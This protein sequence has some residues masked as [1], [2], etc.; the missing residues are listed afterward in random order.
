MKYKQKGILAE[1]NWKPI[2]SFLRRPPMILIIVLELLA[3][4]FLGYR[5]VSASEPLEFA[6][7]EL[8]NMSMS[9]LQTDADGYVGLEETTVPEDG[10]T[11]ILATEPLELPAG[12]YLV[13]VNYKAEHSGSDADACPYIRFYTE[14]PGT[15]QM[16]DGDVDLASGSRTYRM[17]T[18][19][20][21]PDAQILFASDGCRFLV[22][23]VSVRYDA[24]LACVQIILLAAVFVALDAALLR[25]LPASPLAL[26]AGDRAA[27]AGVFVV[28]VL[29]SAL[30]LQSGPNL[31]DDWAFHLSRIEFTADALRFGQFPVRVYPTAKNGYGYGTPL[32]YG[33]LF[34]YFPA[35]LR[36]LGL[37]VGTAIHS[38]M[39]VVTAATAALSY[40]CFWRIFGRRALALIGSFLYTLASYR[41]ICVYVRAA[42]GEYTAMLFL[43]LLVWGLWRLYGPEDKARQGAWVP[44]LL[45]FGGLLQSH[46]LS[47]L[48]AALTALCIGLVFWKRTFRPA[49][50]L[51]WGKAAG[52][53]VLVNLWFLLPFVT[54][55]AGRL[56]DGDSTL[57][58]HAMSLP[59]LLFKG[60]TATLGL[61]LLPGVAL[62]AMLCLY[63][64]QKSVL[65]TLGLVCAG[66]AAAACWLSSTLCPWAM[67]QDSAVGG[68]VQVLQFPWRW[69]GTASL[70]LTL[71]TLCA[72]QELW[73]A[74]GKTTALLAA[75]L[76][77]VL[78]L[79]SLITFSQGRV[80]TDLPQAL[81]DP[82]QTKPFTDLL[83]DP[84]GA[85]WDGQTYGQCDPVNAEV[86]DIS[87]EG[88]R[89]T[90]DCTAGESEG[91]IE[92]PLLYYP[93]YR[94]QAGE[95]T[96]YASDHGLVGLAVP[97]G[98][99]GEVT[100]GYQEP[101]RWLLADAVSLAAAAGLLGWGGVRRARRNGR[102]S[103]KKNGPL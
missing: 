44:L 96:L 65:R 38:Y 43:P 68:L 81:L 13:T 61:A 103:V 54:A 98:W 74:R 23:N 69:L 4:L 78:T 73:C 10:Y 14:T 15:L 90:I 63:R 99:S 6:A 46:M 17:F 3:L 24:A 84:V 57:A 62:F 35:L 19:G 88:G 18:Q 71:L 9:S 42:L 75:V 66:V 2:G 45:A 50:L 60:R 79:T 26:C 86:Y 5:T 1:N 34:L 64:Q 77:V 12:P 31:G 91:F 58:A 32:F 56:P 36:L 67:L 85:Q 39:H 25:L 94:I 70:A 87:R 11:L 33:Q 37:P 83:Y 20:D 48:M 95:G 100:V 8:M 101:L 59:Q 49:T 92:L 76:P 80:G 93:G 55:S 72:L 28:F 47:F 22:G 30:A 40:W 89:L 82:S 51:V 52:G 53:C 102:K 21:C 97:A 29:A 16:Y 27:V 7:G 41:L